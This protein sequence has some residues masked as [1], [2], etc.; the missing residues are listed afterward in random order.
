MLV[1]LIRIPGLFPSSELSQYMTICSQKSVSLHH[2]L[3]ISGPVSEDHR[4]VRLPGAALGPLHYP[5]RRLPAPHPV[6]SGQGPA[7]V[8]QRVFASL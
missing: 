8:Q 5:E 2:V 4:E 6:I 3:K 1:Q 7:Q